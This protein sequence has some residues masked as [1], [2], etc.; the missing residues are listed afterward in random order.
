MYEIPIILACYGLRR[1]EICALSVDDVDGDVLN[2][3]KAKVQDENGKWVIKST[4]T[5]ASTRKIIIPISIS[6]KIRKQGYVY[7]GN[8]CSIT[9]FLEDSQDSLNIPRFSVHKL[10]HY[11]ASKMSS[12][13]I[14]EEDIMKMGGWETDHVMKSVYRH[15]MIE[16]EEN[17]KRE[18]AEKMQNILFS[19]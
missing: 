19:P 18:A 17:A 12:M 8:P 15:S 3:D 2:I 10:R 7:R 4:K 6:E 14:P 5:T 11:F 13:N 16:K 9:Q 1:S